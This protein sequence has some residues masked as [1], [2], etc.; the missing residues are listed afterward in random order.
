LGQKLVGMRKLIVGLG[1]M[2]CMTVIIV[3][4]PEQM[5]PAAKMLTPIAGLF[6]GGQAIIDTVKESRNGKV[7]PAKSN[8]A[9][10]KR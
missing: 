7:T 6:I 8:K 2:V 5:E 3:A 4:S 1:Y 9:K 10:D